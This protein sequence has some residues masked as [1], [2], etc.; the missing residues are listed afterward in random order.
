MTV[1][2]QQRDI[3]DPP[4]P[5]L[6]AILDAQLHTHRTARNHGNGN[7]VASIGDASQPLR[8]QNSPR[9][10]KPL[11]SNP[12]SIPRTPKSAI[13]ATP[14]AHR[15]R[16]QV[17]FANVYGSN[18]H[19]TPLLQPRLKKPPK[20]TPSKLLPSP[21]S[22]DTSSTQCSGPLSFQT[23]PLEIRHMIYHELLQ[24]AAPIRKPHK[25][26]CNRRSIMVDST[27]PVK[28]IDSS[29]LRVCRMIYF[30]AVPILYGRNTFEFGK[31]R[32]LRDFSHAGLDRTHPSKLTSV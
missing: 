10:P 1:S 7:L 20:E 30:E 2:Q 11:I 6:Q 16:R 32:K 27:Q 29:I 18:R 15:T 22:S 17:T 19:L 23:L 9:H 25:L 8:S 3:S 24:S 4:F 26:V 28:D 14:H 21:P 31:P 13:R 5:S 12:I